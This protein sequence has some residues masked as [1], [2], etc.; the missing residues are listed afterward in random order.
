MH[1]NDKGNPGG[2]T[3]SKAAPV[4]DSAAIGMMMQLQLLGL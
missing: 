4:K 2:K 1:V 3:V